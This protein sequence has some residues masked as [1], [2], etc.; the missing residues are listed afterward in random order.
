MTAYITDPILQNLVASLIWWIIGYLF[1]I[2]KIGYGSFRLRHITNPLIRWSI[3]SL[4][5]TTPLVVSFFVY[6]QISIYLF[7]ISI[8][9]LIVFG[10]VTLM[11]FAKA[12]IYSAAD[13]TSEGIGFSK[14]LT[15]VHT[16]F[17]FLGIGADKLTRD[18]EFEKAL[19]RVSQGGT[20]IRL[21]LS[22]PEN[23]LLKQAASRAGLD[24]KLYQERVKES[25][26]R[27]ADF[28]LKKGFNIEVR[29]YPAATDRDYQQFR[30]MLINS[31]IC[32][33]SHT[34]WDRNDG[35]DNPQII[36][37][38]KERKRARQIYSAF[39][40]YF[41]RIWNDSNTIQVNLEKYK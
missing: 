6:S 30:L 1:I 26:K 23:P 35:S 3:T 41:D 15:L 39:N 5:A 13:K 32:I 22:P 4:L 37:V 19:L 10:Y 21:L 16:K 14:S 20:P 28:R 31:R 36:I 9:V 2:A 29:F 18:P 34:V 33:L 12:G 38:S 7:I 17:D 24:P 25:L 27:L 11:P 40:D 8:F